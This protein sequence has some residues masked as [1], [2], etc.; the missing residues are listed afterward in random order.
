MPENPII[1]PFKL[2]GNIYF[3]GEYRAS[4]HLI[5]TGEG[6]ILI[7][8][9]YEETADIIMDNMKTLG[10]DI[11]DVKIILF[12]HGHGDH[13]YGTRKLL[14]HCAPETYIAEEDL[15]YIGEKGLKIHEHLVFVPNHYIKDGM[16]IKLGNTE[17]LCMYT[18]GHTMGT[19]SF[20]WDVEEN[21]VTYRAGM[22]GGAGV[23]QMKKGF[24]D[25]RDLYYFQRGHFYESLDKLKDIKVDV[26]VG[27][28]VWNNDTY[29]RYLKSLESDKNPFIDDKAFGNFI[30]GK[31]PEMDKMIKADTADHFVNFAHRG[32]SEYAPENTIMSFYLGMFMGANGI[33]TDVQ[34][35]KDGVLVLFHDDTLERVT[36]ES[37][38]IEDYTF[39]ELQRFN[40]KKGEL[41][42]KIVSFE[43]F[44]I[45]FAH[46]NITFAIELKKAGLEKE[47][48]ELIYKYGI[49]KK[50]V[51]TSFKYDALVAMKSASPKLKLGYLTADVT[52]GILENMKRDG[53]DEICPKAGN[54]SADDVWKWQKMGFNVRAWGVSDEA[55]MKKAYDDGVNGMTCNFPDKLAETLKE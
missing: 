49:E 33:E 34:K 1:P 17:I 52:D 42:D 26:F 35:T 36:G 20:F 40:V 7:D 31:Y 46:R 47:V 2:C 18:P 10:F 22:F 19:Y 38:T 6:L 37:G 30:N 43:D 45:H 55:V 15:R 48:S 51:V 12:S 53:I 27:N 32:A 9:G 39:E 21:G 24:L 44:L 5:D 13:V 25:E 3:V 50:C 29:G 4:S 8:T 11:K 16:T 54:I 14:E 23:N 41:T 28:H